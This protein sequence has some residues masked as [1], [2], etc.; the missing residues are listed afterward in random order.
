[1][2]RWDEI[3]ACARDIA[4]NVH[5]DPERITAMADDLIKLC[6]L[7]IAAT[8]VTVS[9]TGEVAMNEDPDERL[10][11]SARYL[12]GEDVLSAALTAVDESSSAGCDLE[13]WSDGRWGEQSPEGW[14]WTYTDRRPAAL[15]DDDAT[16]A[17]AESGRVLR[18][19][20]QP[21]TAGVAPVCAECHRRNGHKMDCSRGRRA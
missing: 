17:R 18:T 7:M 4:T 13:R 21:G 19:Q 9:L 1:M 11:N 8:G 16:A 12:V 15:R 5:D 14:G 2:N 10:A 3:Q 20:H 6:G